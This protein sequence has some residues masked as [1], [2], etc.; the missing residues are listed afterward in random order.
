MSYFSSLIRVNTTL[1]MLFIQRLWCAR[2]DIHSRSLRA[3]AKLSVGS[4]PIIIYV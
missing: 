4:F 3:D 1:Q 2:M